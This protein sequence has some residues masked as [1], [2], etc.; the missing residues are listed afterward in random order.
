MIPHH[1]YYQLATLGRL[2][3]CIMLHAGWL[4]RSTMSHQKPTE[5]VLPHASLRQLLLVP[6]P[7]KVSSSARQCRPYTPVIA[8]D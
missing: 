4:S 2:G 7:T 6:E 8:P 1:V 5:F 3:L